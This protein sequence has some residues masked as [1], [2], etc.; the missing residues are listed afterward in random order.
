MEKK[1]G[2]WIKDMVCTTFFT[3]NECGMEVCVP[4]PQM[5]KEKWKFCPSCGIG[6]E[7]EEPE[8]SKT[9]FVE[10]KIQMEVEWSALKIGDRIGDF[11]VL[12]VDGNTATIQ[13]FY[14]CFERAFDTDDDKNLTY[15]NSEIKEY[16]KADYMSD[17]EDQKLMQEIELRRISD[18]DL[19]TR[20]DIDPE[21][22]Q[23]PLYED[24]KNLPKFDEDG[25][26]SWWWLQDV[27]SAYRGYAYNVWSVNASGGVNYSAAGTGFR[28]APACVIN[29]S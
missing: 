3:C 25:E 17:Y 29:L 6:M 20:D 7:Y 1:I 15:E 11:V 18:W 2:H 12:K 13:Q 22:T 24:I 8:R 26:I 27:R 19:L 28:L 10:R 14:N 4:R 21:K 5:L 23:Y 16:L 9:V